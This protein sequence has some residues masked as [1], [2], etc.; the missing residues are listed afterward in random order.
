M[1]RHDPDGALIGRP[2]IP[3][4]AADVPRGGAE[5]NRPLTAAGTSLYPVVPCAT[6]PHP[7]GPGRRP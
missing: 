1:H 2:D 6:G 4:T 3:E 5:R 7:A